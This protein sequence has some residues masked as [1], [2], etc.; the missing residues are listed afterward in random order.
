MYGR[1]GG[2]DNRKQ[3]IGTR[4]GKLK[5]HRSTDAARVFDVSGYASVKGSREP[6][7]LS[8]DEKPG[9]FGYGRSAVNPADH[10]GVR[11]REKS[12][13]TFMSSLNIP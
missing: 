5:S 7:R 13:F 2:E 6:R 8:T 12:H 4:R 3:L 1:T 11:S 10:A 9:D